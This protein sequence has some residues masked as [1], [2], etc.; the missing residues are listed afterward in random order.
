MQ[1][2]EFI[3]LERDLLSQQDVS[4]H[5]QPLRVKAELLYA[6]TLGIQLL[7]IYSADIVDTIPATGLPPDHLKEAALI[8]LR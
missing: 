8:I 4:R 7:D 3:E 6:L 2:L 5:E 1:R